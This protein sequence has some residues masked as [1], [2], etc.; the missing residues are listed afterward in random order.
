MRTGNYPLAIERARALV[1][2]FPGHGGAERFLVDALALGQGQAAA[3]LAAYQWAQRRP[4]SLPAQDTL[5]RLAFQGGYFFLADQVAARVRDLGDTTPGFPLEVAA[6]AEL[7]LQPDG[8]MG[9]AQDQAR[10]DLGKLHLEAGDFAGAVQVL[11]G[12]PITPARNNRG[13]SLFHL[14][15]IDAAQAAFLYAWQAD[16]GNLFGLSWALRLRLWRGDRD[17]AQ[18]LAVPLAQTRARRPEDAQAQL[19]GL[20]LLREDRAAWNAFQQSG[21]ADWAGHETGPLKAT[22]L[23]LGACAASRLGLAD[24]AGTLW[25]KSLAQHPGLRAA[26]VNLGRLK[27]DGVPPAWPEL[28]DLGQALPVG[29]IRA[30]QEGGATGLDERF[31]ELTASDAYLEAI[32]LGGDEVVREFATFVLKRRLTHRPPAA[33]AAG[34]RSPAAILRDLARLPIGRS[35]D[36]LGLH[37]T[38]REQ[39]LIAPREAAD[40]WGRDGLS[41][42]VVVNTEIYRGPEPSD[43]PA[44][45]HAVLSESIEQQREGN[46]AEAE[47]AI[48]S[49]LARIPD[50]RIALGNLAGIRAAQGRMQEAKDMLRRLVTLHPDYLF[51]RCNLASILIRDRALDEAK[52]QLAGLMERPRLHISEVFV[53]YSTT[54]MLYRAQGDKDAANNLIAQLEGMVENEDEALLLANAKAKVALAT[55]GGRFFGAL[56][57]AV[58]SLPKPGRPKRR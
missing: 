33:G 32:Y 58:Q 8:S 13:L 46:L 35:Q 39:G 47:S 30:M 40:F 6:P 4:D 10:F 28:F 17:G 29:W 14:G 5:L 3:A 24:Q 43:L 34:D 15:R 1:E 18:G 37:S 56:K 22:W 7:L 23:H 26:D 12:V 53:L 48:S 51:A 38:M 41:Q 55:A 19:L 2:R 9:T 16:P 20:L 57:V 36:R 31:D 42:V 50:Q 49:I 11:E 27:G 25:R 21:G 45:L 52:D 44:D 54:A